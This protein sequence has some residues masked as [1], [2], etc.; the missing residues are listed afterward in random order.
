MAERAPADLDGLAATVD[1]AISALDSFV[2]KE[3]RGVREASSLEIEDV[4]RE[5]ARLIDEAAEAGRRHIEEAHAHAERIVD[6]ARR[7]SERRRAHFE[8]ELREEREGYERA[9]ADREAQAQARVDEALE[10][11]EARR[12]EADEL[13]ASAAQA[14]ARC[15]HRSTRPGL[16]DRGRRAQPDRAAGADGARDRR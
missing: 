5:R 9:F 7:D 15:W 6:A 10:R 3:L 4:H 16:P 2:Q 12:R 14:Q 13:V 1:A 8:Q 11:A